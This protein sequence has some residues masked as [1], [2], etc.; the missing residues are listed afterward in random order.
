MTGQIST[1]LT[2]RF[3]VA[4]SRGNKYLL[5]LYNYDSNSILTDAMKNRSDTAH[6]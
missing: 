6:L 4:S 1:N 2:G 3:P 5:V